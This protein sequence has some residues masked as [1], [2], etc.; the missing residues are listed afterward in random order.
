MKKVILYFTFSL[1]VSFCHAQTCTTLGQTPPTAF[2]VCGTTIFSQSNVPVCNSNSLFVPGC[3][4][5][6][7]N[8]ANKNP[9]WYKFTCYISGSLG[10]VITPNDLSDD[11][12]WQLYDVT[13]LDPDQVLTNHNIIVTGNWAGNPGTTGAS[14]SG[15]NYIQ[16]AS[17]YNGTESRFSSMPNLVGGHQ[18]ILL[19]SHFT[20]SQS[21]YSLSFGGGTASITDPKL[22]DLQSVNS[23]CDATQIFIKLNKKMKCSSLAAD[24]S[25]FTISPAV[26]NIT[27][28]IGSSCS[29]G[30]DMD[31]IV[32]TLSNPLSPGKYTITIK[33]GTDGNTLL[34]NCDRN[35]PPGNSLK[36]AIFLLEPTPMDSLTTV[37]CAPQTLQLVFIKNILCNSIAVDGSDFIVFGPSPVTVTGAAGN[38]AN[39]VTKN[40]I[41]SLSSPIVNAGAYRVQLKSGSDGNTILD[42]CSQETPSGSSLNFSVKDTVSADFTYRLSEGCKTDTLQFFHDGKNEVNQWTWH[43]DYNGKSSEQNPITYFDTFGQKQISLIVSN[44][45]CSDTIS[46]TISLSNELKAIFETNNILCPEDA[47]T[48]LNK[49]IGNIVAYFWDFGDGATNM[50]KNPPAEN[51]P[52]LS[53]EKIYPI[54]LII[55]NKI[56]CLDTTFQDLKVLK[57]CY[58]AVPN[59]FTPNGD[60]LNDFLY[61]LNAYKA[62]NLEFKVYNRLGQLVFSTTDWTVKWDGSINGQPQD[63]GIYVWTLKYTNHDS[64]KHIFTKGSTM[65]IR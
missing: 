7:A 8:Y 46:K 60:G 51:Y 2:P 6:A 21:G 22:P 34:D 42:E 54:R 5:A 15:V 33:N 45:F 59:A 17:A 28:A 61:P 12:D 62:D 58:I 25:D 35:I 64:G 16:C 27:A 31:S 43:L 38:C 37:A 55:Q 19:V 32:L 40:I 30:F 63:S 26:A 65:L 39:G 36:L 44:G 10:F 3:S 9:F 23:S 29:S 18:Y 13:G 14:A 57:S 56:G 1:S 49:S 52:V 24:G 53:A 48:F 41:V 11:Y 47:A 50:T 4:G 20:D